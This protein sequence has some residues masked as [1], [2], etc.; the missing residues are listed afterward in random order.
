[1]RRSI[2]KM[3]LAVKGKACKRAFTVRTDCDLMQGSWSH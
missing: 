1:M 3:G 2:L